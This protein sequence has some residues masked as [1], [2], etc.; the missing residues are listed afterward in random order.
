MFQQ[1]VTNQSVGFVAA[2]LGQRPEWREPN[3]RF[4]LTMPRAG[5]VRPIV[6]HQHHKRPR[7]P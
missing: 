7:I 2:S 4:I 3:M 6:Q 5:P 1:P